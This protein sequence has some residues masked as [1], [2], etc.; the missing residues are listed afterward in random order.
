[1]MAP[2]IPFLG[3]YLKGIIQ[4][5]KG[6]TCTKTFAATSCGGKELEIEGI[7]INWGT[8]EQVVVYESNGILLCYKIMSTG[9]SGKPGLK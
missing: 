3:L 6:P 5:E 7:V 8:A 4:M 2:T 9:T 1:M